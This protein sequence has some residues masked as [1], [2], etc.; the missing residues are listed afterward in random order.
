MTTAD[1][2]ALWALIVSGL[3]LLAAMAALVVAILDW[4]QITREEPWNLTK[5]DAEH[6]LLERVHRRK[7]WITGANAFHHSPVGFVNDA[8][9]PTQIFR[10][11]T[12]QVLRVEPNG[13][14]STLTVIYRNV[15]RGETR[16]TYFGT[17]SNLLPGE[18]ELQFSTPLY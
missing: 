15:K 9:H 1:T 10:R 3:A 12:R 6:W 11:G 17:G 2:L 4:Q 13:V 18:G 16:N 14:G 8:A 7:V 5:L